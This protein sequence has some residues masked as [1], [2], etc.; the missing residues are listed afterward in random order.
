MHL[1]IRASSLHKMIEIMRDMN[2]DPPSF[3]SDLNRLL[4]GYPSSS[5][6]PFIEFYATPDEIENTIDSMTEIMMRSGISED[7]ELNQLG[8][9][10]ES[11]ISL[12]SSPE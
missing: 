4:P 12:L 7:G 10:I 1:K 6:D 3:L 8:D 5:T 9:D 11:F 2:F